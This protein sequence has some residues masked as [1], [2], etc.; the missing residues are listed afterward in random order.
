MQEVT[1]IIIAFMQTLLQWPLCEWSVTVPWVLNLYTKLFIMFVFAG[2]FT[3][4]W[5]A[6]YFLS[7]E[8]VDLS[9]EY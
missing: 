7:V 3:L 2:F 5:V 1:A 6:Q 4:K 8:I 9:V